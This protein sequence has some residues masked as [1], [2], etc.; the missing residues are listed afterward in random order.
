MTIWARADQAP[1]H[2]LPS[3]TRRDEYQAVSNAAIAVAE[4]QT[5][6]RRE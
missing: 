5:V 1:S 6:L 2:T 3:L 4:L